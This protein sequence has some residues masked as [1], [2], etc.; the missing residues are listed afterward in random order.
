MKQ[1]KN[2]PQGYKDSPLGIIPQEWEVKGDVNFDKLTISVKQIHSQTQSYAVKAINQFATLRNW[3]IGYY[4]VE[5]EQNGEDRAK[6]GDRLLQQLEEKLATKGL[7]ETLFKI[8][9]SFYL[10]YPQIKDLLPETTAEKSA[11]LSHESNIA[12]NQTIDQMNEK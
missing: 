3:L 12:N 10:H 11:T 5:Y 4:I 2:I 7:N 8:S 9:R 6:Y 1:N